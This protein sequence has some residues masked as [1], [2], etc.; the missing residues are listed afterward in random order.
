MQLARELVQSIVECR[1]FQPADYAKRIAALFVE[2]RVVGRG[3]ATEEAAHRLAKGVPWEGAGAPAPAAGNG[4]A[5]RAAPLGLLFG[6]YDSAAMVVAAHEQGQITHQDP[7]CSA[8]AVSI[9]GATAIALGDSPFG[10]EV[11]CMTVAVAG[12]V[13]TTAAMAGAIAGT[14]VGLRNIPKLATRLVTD[15]G[16]WGCNELKTLA[17]DLFRV[18]QSLRYPSSRRAK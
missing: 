12:Y 11:I 14:Y 3:R 1:G 4:S 2:N 16:T 7:R 18:Q 6:T 9:T 10:W 5:M 8:G 17:N 15:Q 13:D